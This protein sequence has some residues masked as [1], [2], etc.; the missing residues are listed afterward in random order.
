MRSLQRDQSADQGSAL[1]SAGF[2]RGPKL[3]LA[4]RPKCGLKDVDAIFRVGHYEFLPHE[5]PKW[6][7]QFL[8]WSGVVGNYIYRGP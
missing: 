2:A 7:R 3:P 8:E 6:N 4:Q 5:G 1:F